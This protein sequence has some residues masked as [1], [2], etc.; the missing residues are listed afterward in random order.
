VYTPTNT[1]N[2]TIKVF[3]ANFE[4]KFTYLVIDSFWEVEVQVISP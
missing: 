2:T 4:A 1:E 3:G